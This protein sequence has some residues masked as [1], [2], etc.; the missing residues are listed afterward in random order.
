MF[1][2]DWF[3]SLQDY[4]A[5]YELDN[6]VPVRQER[7]AG[8]VYQQHQ[9]ESRQ[10]TLASIREPKHHMKIHRRDPKVG[11][12]GNQDP[13]DL[14]IDRG[15]PLVEISERSPQYVLK[16]VLLVLQM[17]SFLLV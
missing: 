11:A 10:G 13:A 15:R 3:A 6:Y 8:G 17:F 2:E 1:S 16:M 9:A 7:A 14:K 5:R 12:R 4:W